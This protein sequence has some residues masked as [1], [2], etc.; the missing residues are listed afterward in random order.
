MTYYLRYLRVMALILLGV[1][2]VGCSGALGSFFIPPT[3]TPTPTP[4]S[5]DD[6]PM[7]LLSPQDLLFG[8]AYT[9][10]QWHNCEMSQT[11]PPFT[12]ATVTVQAYISQVWQTSPCEQ[13]DAKTVTIRQKI[14]LLRTEREA[15]RLLVTVVNVEKQVLLP[16]FSSSFTEDTIALEG[17]GEMHLL[18]DEMGMPFTVAVLVL[19]D[20]PL[21]V[22]VTVMGSIQLSKEDF[23]D[24]GSLLVQKIQTH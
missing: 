15:K 20:G 1:V 22:E 21:A 12:T 4:I 24:I 9:P 11:P 7:F 2:M 19:T 5:V 16:S 14:W 10:D 8:G 23:V 17:G 3:P 6:L 13:M 18:Q